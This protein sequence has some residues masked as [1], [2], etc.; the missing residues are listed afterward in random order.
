MLVDDQNFVRDFVRVGNPDIGGKSFNLE[1]IRT[2]Y[3]FYHNFKEKLSRISDHA[4]FNG[5]K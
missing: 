4:L 1:C 3:R 5:N 2:G